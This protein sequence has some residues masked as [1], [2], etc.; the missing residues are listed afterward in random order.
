MK[1]FFQQICIDGESCHCS[2]RGRNDREL[3]LSRR[4]AGDVQACH[5]GSFVVVRIDRAL[6]RQVAA[7][8]GKEIRF[9]MLSVHDENRP[10]WDRLACDDTHG[11]KTLFASYETFNWILDHSNAVSRK[12]VAILRRQIAVPSGE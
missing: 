7:Q 6:C 5:V 12:T 8:F 3:N 9:L 2:L 10:T 4:I 11:L 1:V